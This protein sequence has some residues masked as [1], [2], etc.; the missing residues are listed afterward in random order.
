VARF[1]DRLIKGEGIP[2]DDGILNHRQKP[3][4]L[5]LAFR[6]FLPNQAAK[7]MKNVSAKLVPGFAPCRIGP[8]V[9]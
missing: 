3:E 4:N 6:S 2:Q 5:Y 8:K 1:G 9:A 7:A